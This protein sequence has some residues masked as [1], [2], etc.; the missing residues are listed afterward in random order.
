VTEKVVGQELE[1]PAAERHP[2]EQASKD[3]EVRPVVESASR[4]AVLQAP[5]SSPRE[6][7]LR[8]Q[9]LAVEL[10]QALWEQQVSV[11]LLQA[12][13]LG[14]L[15]ERLARG[16]RGPQSALARR[17]RELAPTAEQPPGVRLLERRL[18]ASLPPSLRLPSLP[19]PLWP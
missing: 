12:S 7:R 9:E 18:G 19:C 13:L 11:L 3:V 1:R 10:V 15:Q 8:Q 4:L 5:A 14:Q 2:Q 16:P 6:L 17:P